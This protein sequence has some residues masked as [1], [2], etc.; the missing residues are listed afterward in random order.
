MTSS[1]LKDLCYLKLSD[2]MSIFDDVISVK[3]FDIALKLCRLFNFV[4]ARKFYLTRNSNIFN[5]VNMSIQNLLIRARVGT[6]LIQCLLCY[7]VAF[8]KNSLRY[9][10]TSSKSLVKLLLNCLTLK[11]FIKR[12]AEFGHFSFEQM[13]RR[14][15]NCLSVKDGMSEFGSFLDISRQ[16]NR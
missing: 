14:I 8:G 12:T 6:A 1:L 15:Q 11:G 2:M 9:I 10:T 16:K 5:R 3:N 7:R 4:V 13:N